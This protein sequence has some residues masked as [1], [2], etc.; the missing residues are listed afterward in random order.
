LNRHK[1]FK[2]GYV[3]YRALI[4]LKSGSVIVLGKVY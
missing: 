4:T 3:I 2:E 1:K